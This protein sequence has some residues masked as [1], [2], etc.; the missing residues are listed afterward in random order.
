M[1]LKGTATIELV[2]ADGSKEIIKHDNMI[3]NAV[4]DLCFSQRGEM[5]TIL[6][7]VAQNDSYAQAMFGGLLLFGDTLNNDPDDYEIPSTNIIG[8]ASQ[9]AYAGLDVARGSFNETEGGVQA[10]GSYKFVWDFA[11]SQANGTIKSL[12]LCPNIMGQIGASDSIVN[13]E[14]S[15]FYFVKSPDSPF[16]TNG[17]ML[18]DSGSTAGISNWSY[19][20]VAIVDDIAYSVDYY[21]LYRDSSNKDRHILNNGGIL[22]LYKFKLGTNQI[23]LADK[24]SR[25]RYLECIDVQLPTSFTSVL[26]TSYSMYQVSCKFDYTNKKLFVFPIATKSDITVNGTMPYLEIDFTNNM[27]VTS[28]TFTNT[29]AGTLPSTYNAIGCAGSNNE[30]YK[31]LVANDYIIIC[32]DKLYVINRNDNTQIKPAKYKGNDFVITGNFQPYFFN[33]KYIVFK[34]PD[35]GSTSSYY[36][37]ILDFKTGIVKKTNAKN[38]SSKANVDIGKKVIWIQTGIYLTY[39]VTINPFILTTKN[40]LDSPVNKTASQT[41]KITYTLTEVAESEV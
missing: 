33:N 14:T 23:S 4:N 3:T 17:Y 7:M 9:N 34:S 39:Y 36:I 40:N 10:D 11:T 15:D 8:Y 28:L 24:V 41:M 16:N 13:S 12:A 21:N 26:N 38:I 22:K 27:K 19:N 25:A 29:T 2:N 32:T 20:I 6:K 5:A 30:G 37:F 18:K 1:A 31:F 35:S